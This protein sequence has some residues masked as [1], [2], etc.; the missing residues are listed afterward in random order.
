MLGGRGR[1]TPRGNAEWE[2]WF[3]GRSL[4]FMNHTQTVCIVDDDDAVRDSMRVLV[5]SYGHTVR[6][7]PSA[8][9]FLS[10]LRDPE[11]GCLLLDLHMPGMGGLEL[12][13]LLRRRHVRTPII[14]VTAR[15]DARQAQQLKDAKVLVQLSKPVTDEELIGWIERAL[16]GNRVAY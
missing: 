4:N 2:W 3:A 13:E 6:D 7:Y 5:E 12:V 1:A 14:I 10:D 9:A 16:L 11:P 8:T 15:N